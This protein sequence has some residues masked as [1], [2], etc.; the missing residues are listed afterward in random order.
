VLAELEVDPVRALRR[1][2]RRCVALAPLAQQRSE[3]VRL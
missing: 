1:S 3:R 2:P